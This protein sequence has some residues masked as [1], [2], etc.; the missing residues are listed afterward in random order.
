M[1][2]N[3]SVA[4]M[5]VAV[6]LGFTLVSAVPEQ[7]AMYATPQH[8][9]SIESDGGETLS[10]PEGVEVKKFGDRGSPEDAVEGTASVAGD[11]AAD[12]AEAVEATRNAASGLQ[13]FG[14]FTWYALD[15]LIAVGV[16]LF[17]KRRFS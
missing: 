12:A 15:A 2:T 16:Y 7:L 10:L 13:T 14:M 1:M 5:L 17:A 9:L 3:K 11:A 8:M 6:V 4:Y